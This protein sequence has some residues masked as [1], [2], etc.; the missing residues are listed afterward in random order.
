M[1]TPYLECRIDAG[2][3]AIIE[4]AAGT[5][6]THN[7]ARIVAR[8]IMERQDLTI[9]KMVIVTFTRA[10]AG[11]LKTRIA[12]LLAELEEA[13]TAD[14]EHELIQLAMKE[15]GIAA[16]EL[17]KRLRMALLNFDQ[18]MIGT[19]H[20]FAMR[21]LKENSFNGKLKF[22]FTLNEGTSAIIS[23]LCNDF[24]RGFFYEKENNFLKPHLKKDFLQSYCFKRMAN[25][26]MQILW[27]ENCVSDPRALWQQLE[28][29]RS[30]AEELYAAAAAEEQSRNEIK[31]EKDSEAKKLPPRTPERKAANAIADAA[32]EAWREAKGYAAELKGKLTE[33]ENKINS[34]IIAFQKE[35][36][37]K[38]FEFVS[39]EFAR[40]CNEK[41]FLGNDDLILKMR[42]SVQD[43]AF[44]R[45]LQERFTVGL[46]DEFQDTNDTQFEIFEKIFLGNPSSTFIVVGDPRQAIYRF[47]NCDLNTYLA[48]R[49]LMC[50]K[51]NAQLFSMNLNRRSGKR[52]IDML[53]LIFD[54][55]NAFAM[56]D[57]D[58][59]MP[60]Q[61]AL[62][63]AQVLLEPG[64]G[65]EIL[66]PIEAAVAP[67]GMS[68]DD[69]YDHCAADIYN[70]IQA[71]YQIP[72]TEKS[73]ARP[74]TFGDFAIL[75][76]GS[77]TTHGEKI[78]AA[79]QKYNIPVRLMKSPNVF[80]TPEA[81][82]LATFLEGILNFNNKDALL[83]AL[84]TPIGDLSIDQLSSE[85]EIQIRTAKL[86]ELNTLWY[87]RSFMVMYNEL[88]VLF[89]LPRRLSALAG[90]ERSSANFN[91]IADILGEEAFMYKLTP[92]AVLNSLL[93]HINAA[94][95]NEK[96]SFR[97]TPETDQGTVIVDTVFGSKGL[98]YPMVF[99]PDLY[100]AGKK[101][102]SNML[103]NTFHLKD[104]LVYAPVG[105]ENNKEMDG[106]S[107]A[108][109]EHNEMLQESLRIAY[110][111]LTRAKYYCRIYCGKGKSRCAATDWL[112]R[113]HGISDFSDLCETLKS[114][115]KAA[116]LKPPVHC[117]YLA[118]ESPSLKLKDCCDHFPFFVLCVC[119]IF[120]A[121][122][123][124][125]W[126]LSS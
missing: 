38:T 114:A 101:F 9:D 26:Q 99:L 44:A 34:C 72:A 29:E 3:R 120:L 59:K 10:A 13:V 89:D 8:L 12:Q 71:G 58:M 16:D 76:N 77:W 11:E 37:E 36:C 92:R 87:K 80:A 86:N 94:E 83:R 118:P 46:I 88:T 61:S 90:G 40:I 55:P 106:P 23:E 2:C 32:K 115:S 97:G 121:V 124:G 56:P 112:F 100:N 96:D 60:E 73:P 63:D 5:G 79:L 43:E 51:E 116:P 25:P 122:A 42:D 31:K 74:V 33:I 84:L 70:M 93:K 28:T 39:G 18:A 6:K 110:V 54:R 95:N 125:M 24:Y 111:A 27:P 108:T 69:I 1:H 19:I 22:E 35:V 126:D 48:A 103:N 68:H 113:D 78:R 117:E 47:R 91:T 75:T 62:E 15:K 7:I 104:R 17:R 49:T 14:P 109:L 21:S 57:R 45:Q 123:R 52:Y 102:D 82:Q 67:D 4:A 53:N 98:S 105:L 119:D 41:N 50:E 20:S 64:G 81:L 66:T 30:K 107:P 85:E 65:K